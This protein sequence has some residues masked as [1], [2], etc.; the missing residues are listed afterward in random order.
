M[1]RMHSA[2]SLPILLSGHPPEF[3]V[4]DE[5]EAC[6]YLD[7]ERARLPL[8]LPARPLRGRELDERLAGGDRRN[9]PLLYR[10]TC[11]ECRACRPLRIDAA[12]FDVRRRHLRVWRKASTCV[13]VEL[14]PPESS[15]ERVALYN[16]HLHG[17]GL[18]R[19]GP[20]IDRDGY[21]HFL[22]ETCCD[23]F[24]LRYRVEGKLVGVAIT[25]RSSAALSAVYCY[26]DPAYAAL[27]LGTFSVLKQLALCQQWG[28]RHLYLGLYVI[29]SP[30]MA[31]KARF[32]PH[33]Q[34][35]E[36]VWREL[37]TIEEADAAEAEEK[38]AVARRAART[39]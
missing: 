11:P 14:G 35:I 15:D 24:E 19:G 33:E 27:S 29:A 28:L 1:G 7:G 26:Y 17:R 21:H 39:E 36:G 6:P 12:K 13:Q 8:R 22:A 30:V 10:C 2:R 32:F 31:Y 37:G 23:T 25:D 9:G 20:A 16:A 18:G 3:L 4:H 34:R 38:A 5:V